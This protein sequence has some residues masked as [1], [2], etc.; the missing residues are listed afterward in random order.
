[1]ANKFIEEV[2]TFKPG[3]DDTPKLGMVKLEIFMTEQ[4][5]AG[6]IV[7]V[8]NSFKEACQLFP[9]QVADGKLFLAYVFKTL[10]D[11]ELITH[12][13]ALQVFRELGG[14]CEI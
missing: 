1:M 6:M 8:N 13:A 11:A 9:G 4:G 5:Q 12:E 3:E 7:S 10:E 14:P 2:R